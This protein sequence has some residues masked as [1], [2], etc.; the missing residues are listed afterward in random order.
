MRTSGDSWSRQPGH[1]PRLQGDLSPVNTKLHMGLNSV[2]RT[3]Q[4]ASHVPPDRP[5][6]SNT[7]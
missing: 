1:V 7:H 3:T 6:Q 4:R 5:A 2:F